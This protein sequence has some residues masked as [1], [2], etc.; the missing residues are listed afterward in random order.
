MQKRLIMGGSLL[1]VTLRRLAQELIE[2]H[3]D[4]SDSA[5]IG[6]QPRGTFLAQRLK[7]KLEE[8]LGKEVGLGFLDITFYRDDF[9]RRERPL[10]AN[11]TDIP[12]LLEGKKVVLVDDVLFTGRSVRAALDA[13]MA[14]G[15][16]GKVELLTLANRRYGRDLP[17]EAHYTGKSFDTVRSQ[18]IE[19]EWTEQGHDEDRVWLTDSE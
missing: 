16:P 10:A 8:E 4:F 5:L 13:M 1:D 17:I 9:R 18:R 19:V 14:F 2:N 11:Q 6:L 15:R 7:A 3:G 12:F